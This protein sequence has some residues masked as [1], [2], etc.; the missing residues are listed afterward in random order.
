VDEQTLPLNQRQLGILTLLARG[1]T[2][3]EIAAQVGLAEITVKQ[4]ITVIFRVLGVENRSQA[5]L[6]IRRFGLVPD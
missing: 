1:C 5:L 6:A 2:N 3:R 4:H